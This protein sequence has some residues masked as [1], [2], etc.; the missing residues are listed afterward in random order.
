MRS[1]REPQAFEG[2]GLNLTLSRAQVEVSLLSGEVALG[3][4]DVPI[5]IDYVTVGGESMRTRPKAE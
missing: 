3:R 2:E 5:K 1:A 4:W